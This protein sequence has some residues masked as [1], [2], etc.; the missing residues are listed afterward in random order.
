MTA[1]TYTK[2]RPAKRFV[3]RFALGRAD[4]HHL[5]DVLGLVTNSGELAPDDNNVY[6]FPPPGRGPGARDS[7]AAP[8]R[9]RSMVPEGLRELPPASVVKPERRKPQPK[10]IR[11]T[12]P[13]EVPECG[14][15]K[16]FARHRRLGEEV[17][18]ACLEASREYSRTYKAKA[19]RAKELKRLA[20]AG[21]NPA[22]A[23]VLSELAR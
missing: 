9:D 22:S 19:R 17:D 6:N 7:K 8:T 11:P 14:S 20:E 16:A 1:P 12:K 15:Y 18:D 21:V 10:V 2:T 5:L 4:E 13:R 23:Q 3:E